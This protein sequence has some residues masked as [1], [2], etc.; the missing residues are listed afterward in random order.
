MAV[1]W[2]EGSEQNLPLYF[3]VV[4]FPHFEFKIGTFVF[5]C[6]LTFQSSSG[7][8]EAAGCAA[9]AS[10]SSRSKL[11]TV[12]M[13]LEPGQNNQHK[14]KKKSRFRFCSF[15][16]FL[17]HNHCLDIYL[18]RLKS[19]MI[20]QIGEWVSEG[21]NFAV[22]RYARHRHRGLRRLTRSHLHLR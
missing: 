17:F 10:P 7:F 8:E 20:W 22:R 1:P 21:K 19:A 12:Q 2:Q 6:L 15:N 3:L 14:T 5:E 11:Q 9:P 18:P 16:I 4:P 13:L